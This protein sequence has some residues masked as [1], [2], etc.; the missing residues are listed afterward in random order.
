[1]SDLNVVRLVPHNEQAALL[2]AA[3]PLPDVVAGVGQLFHPGEYWL[4]I[5]QSCGHGQYFGHTADGLC[6]L[7]DVEA[8]IRRR[9]AI[10][11][12]CAWATT[13]AQ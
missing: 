10:C 4:L 3:C 9:Y 5:Y 8:E 2:S 11:G 1:M 12:T 13:R 6:D 7:A